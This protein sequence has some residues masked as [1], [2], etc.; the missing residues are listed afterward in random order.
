MDGTAISD[1]ELSFPVTLTHISF[2]NDC[3]SMSELILLRKTLGF[4]SGTSY[5]E[6]T[7][8]S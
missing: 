4:P 8:Y 2:V 7:K 5:S 1:P 6:G 3:S